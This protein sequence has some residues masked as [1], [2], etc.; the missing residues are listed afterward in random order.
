LSSTIVRDITERKKI[1][2]ALRLSE[3]KFSKAFHNSQTMM[4][5]RRLKD[6]VYID[7]NQS[8]AEVLGYDRQEMIGKSV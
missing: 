8:Y 5:I 6:E 3:E 2:A 4:A 1:E 7:V